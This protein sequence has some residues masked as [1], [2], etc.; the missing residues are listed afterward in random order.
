MSVLLE[1]SPTLP[2]KSTF[3]RTDS[4]AAEL[5]EGILEG[6]IEGVSINTGC[7]L[8]GNKKVIFSSASGKRWIKDYSSKSK[9]GQI[10]FVLA[11][12]QGLIEPE[13]DGL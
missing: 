4:S 7:H 12:S 10:S 13:R 2:V 1:L 11:L 6:T 9:C 8:I 3:G 5:I